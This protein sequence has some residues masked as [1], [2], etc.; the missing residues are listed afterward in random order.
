MVNAFL[1]GCIKSTLD[2]LHF[3][4]PHVYD[5]NGMK[6]ENEESIQLFAPPYIGGEWAYI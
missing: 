4:F 2:I 3:S 6:N 1:I 5:V